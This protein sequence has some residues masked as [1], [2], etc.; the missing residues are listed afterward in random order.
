MDKHIAI[1]GAG[2]YQLPL[3]EKAKAMGYTTHVFAWAAGDVGEAVADYF[4]PISITEREQI[5]EVCKRIGVSGVCSIGSDLAMLTV[6]FIA[7][8]MGLVGNSMTA[9][10]KS[11][12]KHAMRKAFDVGGDPSPRSILVEQESWPEEISMQFPVI[13]KPTDRSGS[14]GIQKVLTQEALTAAVENAF[15]VSFEKKALIEEYA[16]GK[17]Y[18][19]EYISQGGTHTFL[20]LTEKRTTGAPAFI[21]TGHIEPADISEEKLIEIQKIVEHALDTLEIQN[22][23]SHSEIKIADDGTIKIIEIGG[24]MG[25]DCIGSHLVQYATGYDYVRMVISVACGEKI[26]WTLTG[27]PQKV[28]A[29]FIMTAAD[30]EAYEAFKSSMPEK[31]LDTIFMETENIGQTTD[32]SNRAGC[33]IIALD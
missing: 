32:S 10:I 26:D 20:A 31:L 4:Y 14:R 29:R 27:T 15:A 19:V 23:A 21:E 30:L 18:S 2:I 12:N 22:G 6:N 8:A 3:I 28:E 13:V 11:T 1:I 7:E 5:L 17:E 24:R 16:E 9:T 25:G 33:Y